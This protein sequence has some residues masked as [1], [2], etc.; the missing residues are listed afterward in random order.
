MSEC[1][2][3]NKKRESTNEDTRY[4]E[5]MNRIKRRKEKGKKHIPKRK[6]EER[7]EYCTITNRGIGGIHSR[8]RK[9]GKKE[10]EEEEH[11]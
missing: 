11:N 6:E 4:Q 3:G 5:K 10:D 1:L 8:G 2:R 7:R 9:R